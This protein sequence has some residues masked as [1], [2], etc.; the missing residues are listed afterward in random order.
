MLPR[1]YALGLCVVKGVMRGVYAEQKRCTCRFRSSVEV[2]GMA[3]MK[4]LYGHQS[5]LVWYAGKA[6]GV[7]GADAQGCTCSS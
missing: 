7:P 2:A 1:Q 3:V 6:E 5:M 4:H